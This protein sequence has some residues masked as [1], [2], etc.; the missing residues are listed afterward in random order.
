MRSFAWAGAFLRMLAVA[1]FFA[2]ACGVSAFAA[3]PAGNSADGASSAELTARQ[4][5]DALTPARNRLLHRLGKEDDLRSLCSGLKICLDIDYEGCSEGDKHPWPKLK[6]DDGFCSMYHEVVAR[7]YKP[8][9]DVPMAVDVFARL[10]RRYRAIY[11]NEGTLPLGEN[12]ISYLFDNMPFTADLINAY[13]ES[14]YTLEYTSRNHRFFNGSNG[15]SLS[16]EFYWA[17]Q[18]SAGCKLGMRSLFFGYGHAHVLKWS[19]HGSA[20]AFLDMEEISKHELKYKLTAVV[21]PGNSV[22]NS[23][24]QM[25]VFKSVVNEKIDDIVK[26]IKKAA[27]MYFGGNKEPLLKSASLKSLDNVQYVLDFENVVNGA[28][29]KLGDFE[30]L[31]KERERQKKMNVPLKVED[32]K[33]ADTKAQ[34]K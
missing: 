28:P 4:K 32:T 31:Q 17:L 29:W 21:F 7:G 1:A 2:L 18:D 13:L 11:I 6:Y 5:I 14:N 22:L 3:E 15:R 10:G 27:G 8:E 19:L 30:K 25:R 23:I 20:I 34:K 9:P 33:A 24:M 16:G 12:V 26:D